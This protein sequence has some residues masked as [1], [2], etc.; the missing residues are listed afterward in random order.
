MCQSLMESSTGGQVNHR[1]SQHKQ[2]CVHI[3]I[4]LSKFEFVWISPDVYETEQTGQF[5]TQ[6]RNYVLKKKK[7]RKEKQ[8]L[9]KRREGNVH[10]E[11]QSWQSRIIAHPKPGPLPVILLPLHSRQDVCLKGWHELLHHQ[12]TQ[13]LSRGRQPLYLCLYSCLPRWKWGVG[14][15][16]R[17]GLTYIYH[18]IWNR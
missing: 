18:Y 15:I 10:F 13:D 4:F 2:N 12:V 9:K 3:L 17:L 1:W 14:W 5:S 8:D 6:G 7:K 16:G 11:Q